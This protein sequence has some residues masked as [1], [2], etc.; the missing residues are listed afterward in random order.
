MF[1]PKW[2]R[3]HPEL[4]D[5][6]LKRRGWGNDFERKKKLDWLR[7]IDDDRRAVIAKLQVLL[8]Y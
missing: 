1:D 7:K 5:R 6:G 3:D 8:R 4:L 2:V